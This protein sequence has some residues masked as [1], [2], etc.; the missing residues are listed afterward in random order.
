M[1]RRFWF[2]IVIGTALLVGIAI[3][4]WSRDRTPIIEGKSVNQW[5]RLI[6]TARHTEAIQVLSQHSTQAFPVVLRRIERRKGV[7]SSIARK[8]VYRKYWDWLPRRIQGIIPEPE[9]L[10][11]YRRT[12]YLYLVAW[13]EDGAAFVPALLMYL[14]DEEPALRATAAVALSLS[15]VDS[16]QVATAMK[17]L[18]GDD[19]TNVRAA[20]QF[21]KSFK[22]LPAHK[23][24]VRDASLGR[25]PPLPALPAAP[26]GRSGGARTL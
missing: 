20:A 19:D 21:Y 15:D 9:A 10:F 7:F 4:W 22:A 8:D 12:F 26:S 5:L 11:A 3:L 24:A 14:R 17:Q 6:A 23:K 2:V 25:S 18:E 13:S 1:K 16:P